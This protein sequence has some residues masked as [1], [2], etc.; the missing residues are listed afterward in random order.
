MRLIPLVIVF[1]Y[2]ALL[3]I[4]TWLTRHLSRGSTIAYLLAGRQ[5]PAGMVAT[6]LAGLAVGGASTVGTA[7]Q[8]YT[9]G[10]SAGW[11]NAAW[12]AGALLMGLVAA[13]RYR[14][15]EICTLSQLF[16]RHYGTLAH[17]LGSIGQIF[18]Q[19]VI[20]SLQ[21]VAGGA[22]LSSLMGEVFTFER[23][24][25]LTACLFVGITLI[26][27][28]WAAGLT[29]TINVIVI[30]AGVLLG[31]VLA[32]GQ[33]G[34]LSSLGDRLPQ[35]HPGFDLGAIG[36]GLIAGW[37][38]VMCT[39]VFS[40]QAVIQ[41]GF[42]AK[43]ERAA[44]VGYLLGALLILP[45]GFLSALIGMA[46]AAIHPGINPTEAL[47]CTVLNLN[48]V[49]AG[50]VLSGLWAADVSTA[51]VLLIGSATLV[52]S[53]M[54]KRFVAPGMNEKAERLA[55]RLSVLALA[56]ATYLLAVHVRGILNALLLGL[57][58]STA[59]TL[60]A[61]MTLYAPGLCRK[62]T[63][64]ATLLTTMAALGLWV[65]VP[66]VKAA[67]HM[68]HPIYFTWIASLVAFA[69]SLALDRRRIVPPAR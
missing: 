25:L 36:A 34:G 51:C 55:C 18:I 2:I 66:Q 9:A 19:I 48:P 68:P 53:D 8:A 64:A 12:A 31:C 26:G 49:V 38:M 59:Y 44:K 6:L 30:Y 3:Y 7:E 61:L 28:F 45:V 11:Y 60:V 22:I 4:V 32:L 40:T 46:G 69:L 1:T 16:E 37:F 42:A 21:Y 14:R 58:L 43:D 52:V 50:L 47:P 29:N 35:G 39:Q 20:T 67:T 62:S 24:M 65:A 13:T 54:L 33:V 56:V 23:G 41:I 17:V 27:G 15:L 5:L 10:L 57:T 63:A